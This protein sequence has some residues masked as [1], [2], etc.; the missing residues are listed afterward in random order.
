MEYEIHIIHYEKLRERKNYLSKRIFE[1]GLGDKTHWLIQRNDDDYLDK[2]KKYYNF[3]REKWVKKIIVSFGKVTPRVLPRKLSR[4][5]ICLAI[6]HLLLYKKLRKRKDKI[7]VIMEDDVIL[8]SD[9]QRKLEFCV[10]KLP[11][12]WDIC[13]VDFGRNCVKKNIE[14]K[15]LKFFIAPPRKNRG[16]GSYLINGKSAGKLFKLLNNFNLSIDQ[17]LL[18]LATK[19]K[20]KSFW[21]NSYLTYQGNVYGYYTTSLGSRDDEY[22]RKLNP[23]K[24]AISRQLDKIESMRFSKNILKLFLVFLMDGIIKTKNF[25]F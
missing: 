13:Y 15:S 12:N 24:R 7:F 6:N 4:G 9:F 23:I 18:Y 19:N 11:K 22:M 21:L 25:L 16:T 1:L 20:I 14:E 10:K 5:E 17:E 2:I 3:D 8:E